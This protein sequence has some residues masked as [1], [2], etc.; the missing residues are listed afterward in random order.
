M[1][2]MLLLSFLFALL[3]AGCVQPLPAATPT[4]T[5]PEK[6]PTN[7]PMYLSSIFKTYV[8]MGGS[9]WATNLDQ[10]RIYNTRNFGEH[11]FDVTP[12]GLIPVDVAGNV[13]MAFPNGDLGW[14]CQS[15]IEASSVLYATHD[16]GQTWNA[17]PQDFSC[18][19]MSFTSATDGMI[20]SDLGVGAGSQ[21]VSIYTTSDGGVEWTKVFEHDASN[22]DNHGLP[23]SGI[24]SSLLLLNNGVALIGG[25]RPMP[26]S[27]YLF[28]STDGGASWDQ[29][30]CAGIPGAEDAELDPIDILRISPQNVVVPVRSYSPEGTSTHFCASN[31]AGETFQYRSTIGFVE[32]TDF[33]SLDQGLAYGDGKMYQTMDGVTWQDVTSALPPGMTPVALHMLNADVGYLTATITPE[34]LLENRIFMTANN[35]KSWQSM[36]GTIIQ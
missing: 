14:I 25:S 11:W 5:E 27:L 20:V 17:Y 24:K 30:E 8:Y 26:G 10:T 13:T 35:G 33:G 34:T 23:A 3:I 28:R 1:K 6:L 15:Q 29:V 12:E 2:K 32:F 22:P 4:P 18:G 36:S 19:N 31:D 21:Y 16:A 7:T 9:G